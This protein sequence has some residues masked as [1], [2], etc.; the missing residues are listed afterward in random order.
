MHAKIINSD[1]GWDV[2]G[3][4][5]AAKRQRVISP[6]SAIPFASSPSLSAIRSSPLATGSLPSYPVTSSPFTSSPILSCTQRG[7]SPEFFD[8]FEYNEGMDAD[9]RRID[10]ELAEAERSRHNCSPPSL[11]DGISSS[12]SPPI[13]AGDEKTWVVFRGKIPGIYEDA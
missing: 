8:N 3:T 6:P 7:S 4:M 11:N 10:L 13:F 12:D 2:N 5:A 9:F 1:N